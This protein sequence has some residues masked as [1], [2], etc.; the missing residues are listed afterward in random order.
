MRRK[1]DAGVRRRRR[2]WRRRAPPAAWAMGT[3]L[4]GAPGATSTGGRLRTPASPT[5]AS[6]SS[7]SSRSAQVVVKP[8]KLKGSS[9]LETSFF[10]Y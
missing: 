5:G 4:R 8:Q 3:A 9:I 6:S 1:L 2:C 7:G 10:K